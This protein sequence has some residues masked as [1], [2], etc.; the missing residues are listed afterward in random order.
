MN[1]GHC[2]RLVLPNQNLTI[3]TGIEDRIVERWGGCTCFRGFGLWDRPDDDGV[4]HMREPIVIVECSVGRWTNQT[5][6]WW[7]ELAADAAKLLDQECVFLSVRSER[8]LLADRN[9]GV[10]YIGAE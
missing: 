2:V 6:Q 5:R 4:T 3:L 10:E 9:G 1:S 7:H 8:A